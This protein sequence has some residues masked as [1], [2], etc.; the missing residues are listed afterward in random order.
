MMRNKNM[1]YV[2][3]TQTELKR[4]LADLRYLQENNSDEKCRLEDALY[5]TECYLDELERDINEVEE[6]LRKS[7]RKMAVCKKILKF[8]NLI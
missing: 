2:G 4:K 3:L 8:E 7:K 6:L 5:E 1:K